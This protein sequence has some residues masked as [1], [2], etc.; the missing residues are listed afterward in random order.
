MAAATTL[1]VVALYES[2]TTDELHCYLGDSNADT[3]HYGWWKTAQTLNHERGSAF[4]SVRRVPGPDKK[5]EPD[6]PAFIE[7]AETPHQVPIHIA[8]H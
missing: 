4:Q 7:E 1:S 6:Q 2:S 3:G 5:I 8:G